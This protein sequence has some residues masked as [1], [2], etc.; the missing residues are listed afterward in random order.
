MKYTFESWS[1][2]ELLELYQE[3][4]LDLNPPYQ[5]NDIWSL[6]AK[7]RL[8]DTIKQGFPLPNFFLYLN[9]SGIYEMVDGQQRTRTFLGYESGMFCDSDKV[10]F[11]NSDKTTFLNTYKLLIVI[12]SEVEDPKLIVEFYHKVNKFGS[13]L[14]RPE[15]LR[16]EHF[17]NPIQEL[18]EEISDM[19]EF[20]ELELFSTSSQNRLM[21]QDYIGEL[22]ALIQYGITDKK[23]HADLLFEEFKTN[24]KGIEN[25][26][27]QF[28]FYLF[29]IKSLND[30]YPLKE[31][32][33]K[34][35]NDFY[36]LISFVKKH[37]ELSDKILLYCYQVLIKIDPKIS[38]SNEDCFA[39]QN[40]AFN[41]VT[42]SNSKKAREERL[43]F[44]EEILLN[45]RNDYDM[46][47]G[48]LEND[49]H[50]TMLYYALKNEDLIHEQSL[51][52][53]PIEKL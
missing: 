38:P 47:A 16:S 44:F 27:D 25:L 11:E 48:E 8:I 43:R 45:S 15:I 22:L 21:D 20:K 2:G 46:N 51:F 6:P 18:I 34:Q 7:R 50:E 23:K 29:K 26:K 42:Q 12:I 39:F 35:R 19:P 10:W 14:N 32:R 9:D 31:T 36:T 37:I 24:Q 40:Y 3:D 4:N 41:C 13:K 28:A 49:F 17:E 52:L 1:I 5:R 33:Y 53:L 30:F